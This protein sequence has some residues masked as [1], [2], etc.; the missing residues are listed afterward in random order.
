MVRFLVSQD[1]IWG[2]NKAIESHNHELARPDDQH[3]LRLTRSISDENASVL[4]SMSQ[5]GIRI[6]DVLTYISD[7]VGGVGNLGF[8]KLDAYNYIQKER[9]DKIETGDTNESTNYVCHGYSKP[10]STITECFLGLEKV[11]RTWHWNEQD[12]EFRC[13]QIDIQPYMKNCPILK[14]SIK[15]YSRKL[16]SFFEEE[17]LHE[18]G[19]LNIEHSSSNFLRFFIKNIDNS[20]DSHNWIVTIN[21][22][23]GT[24]Q[25]SYEKFKMMGILCY[26]CMRVMRQLDIVNIPVKY[27]LP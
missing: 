1:G 14:Q 3:L 27:L 8:N 17:F 26:H 10:T 22:L 9:R 24:I 15:F 11:L 16:Y 5:A 23:E 21:S 13:S 12:E 2:V 7:E 25:C 19:G 4:K 20:T 6:V 18:L